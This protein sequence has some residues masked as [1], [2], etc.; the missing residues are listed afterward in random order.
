M[1][2]NF[3]AIVEQHN[4]SPSIPL[5]PLFEAIINSIQSIEES[6]RNDGRIDIK[7]VREISLY[8]NNTSAWETDVDSFE[9]IDNGVGFNDK[10]Y[11]SFDVYGSEYKF[12]KGCKGVGRITWLK[13]FSSVQIES[14]YLDG[15][16]YRDRNFEFSIAKERGLIHEG[17]SEKVHS[18]TRV[19]LSTYINKYKTKCPKR[20]DTLARD[21][22]NHC[23][24]YLALETCPLIY[25]DDEQDS[26]CI[27]TLFKNNIKGEIKICPFEVKGH[28]FC[29]INAKNYAASTD[30]HV[31]HFCAHQRE[32]NGTTLASYIKALNGKLCNDDGEFVYAGYITG[33]LLDENINSERT[34]F[35]LLKEAID[36][37][38]YEQIAMENV[39][40]KDEITAK[41]IIKSALPI[42][43]GYLAD[44]ISTYSTKKKE[45]IEKYVQTRNPRYRSLLKHDP[46]CIDRIRYQLDDDKLDLELFKQE[47]AYRLKIKQEQT[48][49]VRD[50]VDSILNFEDYT[51]RCSA[52]LEKISDLGKDDLAQYIMHR[53]IML[54]V[55]STNLR[56]TDE[57]KKKYALEKEI[58]NIIFPMMCTSDDI[59]Y[60]KHN[61]WIIDER[62][63]YHYY[64]ASDKAI[65]SYDVVESDCDKEPDIA[66]FEPAFALTD[67][68]R[69]ADINNIT[70]IE[71]KRPGRTDKDCVDQVINYVKK[72]RSG[73]CKDKHGQVLAEMTY[74]NVRFNCYVLCDIASDM[75]DFLE[76][77]TFKKTPDGKS[78]YLYHDS[79]NAYIEVI[80]YRK[81]VDDSIKRNK[82]LFDKLLCQIP[83][84]G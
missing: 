21:I 82:I 71:F 39:K 26:I 74:Q 44:E 76:G 32:V 65:S 11:E 63:S 72:I 34:D 52:F 64:L 30:K 20:L 31:L 22:M 41:D 12:A 37:E 56:Y 5:L 70:I 38:G 77:R 73:K 17:L 4:L 13:A 48:D 53:K 2:I 40:R 35:S 81:L 16:I 8:P 51:Q 43:E 67:D 60:N 6:G 57:S 83:E 18:G 61:L 46:E 15:D 9:I 78:Y 84:Q 1:K 14:T 36:D 62:L 69:N 49:F 25:I 75:A 68:G 54:D 33:D 23:F 79:Y 7:V 28:N 47:Q 80:P 58:H 50:E 27:N 10:N 66:I 45:R 42:I 55:L 19:V 29:V 24:A 3:K 59:D